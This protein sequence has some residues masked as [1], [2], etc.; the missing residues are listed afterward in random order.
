[1]NDLFLLAAEN[2]LVALVLAALVYGLTRI[3]RNPPVAHLLWL[4]VL[5]KLVAPP[6][7]RLD[8]RA[9]GPSLAGEAEN[10]QA[11]DL[12]RFERHQAQIDFPAGDWSVDQAPPGHHPPA[13]VPPFWNRARP[14]LLG[15]WLGGAALC[16]VIAALR[17]VR[18]ER[19]LRGALPASERLQRL[20][21]E[22][23]GKLGVRRVPGVRCADSVAV[24]M[25]WCAGRRPTIVLPLRLLGEL[26]DEQ[27]A[28]ILAHE[29]AHLRRRDHW[30][31]GVEL[32]VSIVYWWNPLVRLIRRQLHQ[33]EDLCCDGWVRWIFPDCPRRYAELLLKAA[34]SLGSSP[35]GRL[36]PASPFLGTPSL[37][38]RIEMILANRFAPRA[39]AKSILAVALVALLVWPSLLRTTGSEALADSKDEAAPPPVDTSFLAK[40]FKYRVPFETGRTQTKVG[41]KIEIREVWGT[42]EKIEIG[43]N[44]SCAASMCCP[45]A[46]AASSI[47]MRRPMVPGARPRRSICNRPRWRDQKA[48]SPSFTAWPDAAIFI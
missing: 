22:I 13:G 23:A 21:L 36:L 34:E 8:W 27:W 28:L 1:M 37:K 11:L 5:V 47:S 16:A 41:G 26:D 33:A 43:A 44:T 24:P 19:R 15:L 10:R 29:L 48:S 6:V 18:F 42:R 9:L 20:T 40:R 4:L 30:L 46:Y 3:W 25:L 39:S 7:F 38:A 32:V 31:R 17:I 45:P 35:V 12:A 2:T 14:I